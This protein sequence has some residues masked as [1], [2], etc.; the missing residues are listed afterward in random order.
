MDTLKSVLNTNDYN[1]RLP[2]A[3][4]Q[5][6]P[7]GFHFN[8][9]RR[10][11]GFLNNHSRHDLYLTVSG[12]PDKTAQ[13][14]NEIPQT[15]SNLEIDKGYLQV[16]KNIDTMNDSIQKK[17]DDLQ[18]VGFEKF[19]DEK[20]K[21]LLHADNKTKKSTVIS[22]PEAS[23]PAATDVVSTNE[24]IVKPIRKRKDPIM[25]ISEHNL[26]RKKKRS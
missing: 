26:K 12:Y 25:P 23:E 20:L 10:S 8:T 17:L 5:N 7:S 3:N 21:E 15:S 19:G 13:K 1:V 14:M 4:F 18:R 11:S 2:K 6:Y 16:I 24:V 22:G 9:P